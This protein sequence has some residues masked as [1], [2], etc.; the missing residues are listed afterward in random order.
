[1]V[2]GKVEELKWFENMLREKYPL[3]MR[4]ILGPDQEST[5]EVVILNR[6]VYCINGKVEFEADPEHTRGC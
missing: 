6:K 4:G 3:K 2:S 1:M 5:K